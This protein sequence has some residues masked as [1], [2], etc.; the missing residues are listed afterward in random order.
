[1]SRIRHVTSLIDTT[2][3]PGWEPN[4]RIGAHRGRSGN[5]PLAAP[6]GGSSRI[7][8]ALRQGSWSASGLMLELACC[9]TMT[10][11]WY[12]IAADLVLVV[13]LLFMGSWWAAPS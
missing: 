9:R 8:G 12:L 5:A 1:M 6:I 10:V 3:R 4:I 7:C 13:H 2:E 11:M